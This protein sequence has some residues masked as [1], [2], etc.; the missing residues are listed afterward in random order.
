MLLYINGQLAELDAGQVIAQTKQVN[1]INSLENRQ[2]GYTNKFNLPKTATNIRLMNFL[3][4]SGNDS[5][6]PYQKNQCSLY[7]DNG[8]CFV[9]N[10]WAVITDGGDSYEAIIYDGIIDLYKA[11]ENK[12]LSSLDLSEINH[13]KNIENVSRSWAALNGLN[14]RYIL[15]DY[16]G[17]KGY[18]PLF[19]STE[20]VDI[21]Y[22]VP[23][24]NVAWLW[25][26]IF[27][28]HNITYNGAV[29]KTQQFKNLWLTYPKGII[30]QDEGTEVFNCTSF[31][32]TNSEYIISYLKIP[33]RRTCL[34]NYAPETTDYLNYFEA[35][36]QKFR[37]KAKESGSYKMQNEY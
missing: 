18:T 14:Y 2:T 26:T 27:T 22:L 7:S 6:I 16:N 10:G 31:P 11:I 9:Y 19:S 25:H 5:D 23:S 1:D 28:T 30:T 17:R 21:D 15:A 29:F 3:T 32:I 20:R 24:I 12:N 36:S 8:E 4:L 37:L 34:F 33:Y 13:T 35:D